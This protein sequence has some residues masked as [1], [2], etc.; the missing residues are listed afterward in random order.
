MRRHRATLAATPLFVAL[1]AGCGGSTEAPEATSASDG[2][3][4]GLTREQIQ[5]RAEAMSPEVAE[6]LGIIDTTIR[7]ERPTPAES[8]TVLPLVGDSAPPSPPL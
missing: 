5:Q 8:L 4:G 1:A 3:V 7:I 2:E 6:S